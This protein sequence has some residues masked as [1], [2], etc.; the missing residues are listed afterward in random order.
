MNDT[1]RKMGMTLGSIALV[2]LV[3]CASHQAKP[4]PKAPPQSTSP[5]FESSAP[6]ATP[7]HPEMGTTGESWGQQGTQAPS[8]S[9]YPQSQQGMQNQP[10]MQQGMQPE[11]GATGMTTPPVNY[12]TLCSSLTSEANIRVDNVQNG[13]ALILTPKAGWTMDSLR[14]K[15]QEVEHA[16]TTASTPGLTTEGECRLFKMAAEPGVT[17]QLTEGGK[18]I[19]IVVTTSGDPAAVKSL[20]K[21]AHDFMQMKK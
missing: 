3:G 7:S 5:T 21:D 6:S 11:P 20:R 12:T 19:K 13:V 17:T 1:T 8:Q 16:M 10:G 14:D 18:S 4:A 9:T 15:A 2:A